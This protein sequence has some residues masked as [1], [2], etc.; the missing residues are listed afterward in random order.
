M[1]MLTS[2]NKSTDTNNLFNKH[3]DYNPIYKVNYLVNGSI[4]TIFI[5]YGNKNEC[6]ENDD[7][8]FRTIFTD[9]E[10]D[11]IHS[12]KINIKCS[13]QKIHYDDSIS[14]IKIKILTE[15]KKNTSID[16]I[17]LFCQ[18]KETFSAVSLYQLLTQN[19]KLELTKIRLEQFISNIVSDEAGNAF[20]PP[21]EKDVYTFEDILEMKIE[22]KTYIVNKV[23]GQKFFIVENEYP[24]V[25]NPYNIT[26]YDRFFEKNAR[27]SLTTLNSH[28]LLNSGDIINNNIYLCLASDVLSFVSKKKTTEL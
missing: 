7:E 20:I 22:G 6:K 25:C 11:E 5:F 1:S 16:E 23:L 26:D 28:L 24:F 13:E 3:L 19:K 10:I 12:K 15:I 21:P 9:K 18:K 2:S 4:D 27:K 8:F 14:T 17:Y